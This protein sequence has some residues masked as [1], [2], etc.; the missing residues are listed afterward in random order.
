MIEHSWSNCVPYF[1]EKRITIIYSRKKSK[2]I[3]ANRKERLDSIS[4]DLEPSHLSIRRFSSRKTSKQ[5]L[6]NFLSRINDHHITRGRYWTPVIDNHFQKIVTPLLNPR[7]L[8]HSQLEMLYNQEWRALVGNDKGTYPNM[9]SLNFINPSQLEIAYKDKSNEPI[10]LG[11]GKRGVVIGGFL[12]DPVSENRFA[13]AI[14]IYKLNDKSPI[15]I[16]LTKEAHILDYIG[17]NIKNI[18]PSSFGLV[19]LMTNSHFLPV[20]LVTLLIGDSRSFEIATLHRLLIHETYNREH[21]PKKKL[22]PNW[23]WMKLLADLF[24]LIQKCHRKSI[25]VNNISMNSIVTTYVDGEGWTCPVLTNFSRATLYGS[26]QTDTKALTATHPNLFNVDRKSLGRIVRSVN[27]AL[28]LGLEDIISCLESSSVL[29][30]Y[31]TLYTIT[32]NLDRTWLETK[33]VYTK[34]NGPRAS[35]VKILGIG[36]V[37]SKDYRPED[38][39]ILSEKD[40]SFCSNFIYL[41]KR[42]LNK[43]IYRQ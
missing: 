37:L 21:R 12:R 27:N 8:D 43:L 24:K 2:L 23:R 11:S 9:F 7:I 32:N 13:V 5:F 25:I 35:I 1:R 16:S 22:M 10:L 4:T 15:A 14:K 3:L 28:K 42:L 39:R 20:A 38:D 19:N 29:D 17:R 36:N 41:K 30:D 34:Q 31:Q 26:F 33:E 6:N 18:A 40:D